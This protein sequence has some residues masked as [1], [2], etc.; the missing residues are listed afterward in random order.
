MFQ[1][2]EETFITP[3]LDVPF[4]FKLASTLE[5]AFKVFELNEDSTF[6]SMDWI[7]LFDCISIYEKFKQ[8]LQSAEAMLP[9]FQEGDAKAL[10]PYT[11]KVLT[12]VFSFLAP[13]ALLKLPH[14]LPLPEMVLKDCNIKI[15]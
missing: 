15:E 9:E 2:D 8:S 10:V 14:N 5:G 1:Q 7:T 6:H 11:P 4:L 13:L 3:I 12:S